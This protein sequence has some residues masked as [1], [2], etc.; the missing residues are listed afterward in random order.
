LQDIL[1]V[2][3]L[4]DI[5]GYF[6]GFFLNNHINIILYQ[7]FMKTVYFPVPAPASHSKLCIARRGPFDISDKISG[8][9]QL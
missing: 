5:V 3:S 4:L 8:V 9:M 1:F 2:N 6:V 7:L